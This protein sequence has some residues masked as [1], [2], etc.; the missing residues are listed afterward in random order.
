MS[1]APLVNVSVLLPAYNCAEFLAQA[2]QS[3][4]DQSYT[5]FELIIIDDGSS[6]NSGKI[7]DDFAAADPRITVYHTENRG[8]VDAL[9]LAA[10]KASGKFLARMDG[11]DISYPHRFARQVKVLEDDPEIVAVSNSIVIID[12]NGRP[13]PRLTVAENRQTNLFSVP[14]LEN[15]LVHPFL[16]MRK[17][18]FD[19]VGGYRHI[20]HSEDAE[21]YYRLEEVGKLKNLPE[22]LGE[23]RVHKGSVSSKDAFNGRL[24]S[25]SAQL[26]ALSARRRRSDKPELELTKDFSHQMKARAKDIFSLSVWCAEEQGLDPEETEWLVAASITKFLQHEHWRPYNLSR[27]D[28]S[29]I[30]NFAKN[31]NGELLG[32][33]NLKDYL[34]HYLW[35][36]KTKWIWRRFDGNFDIFLRLFSITAV[37]RAVFVGAKRRFFRKLTSAKR[38]LG[39]YSNESYHID[40]R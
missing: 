17:E 31:A 28:A 39:F 36:I 27:E 13:E 5:D 9:N 24:Q 25:V 12:Q 26:A 18:A 40:A 6:D 35:V 14:A 20:L 34:R 4:L 16:M 3:I 7:A 37:S 23:Y 38:R 21:L 2:L 1:K 19:R 11:D 10:S 30:R 32:E 29:K 22:V 33:E 15:Y 8:L